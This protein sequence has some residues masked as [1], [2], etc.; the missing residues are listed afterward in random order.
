MQAQQATVLVTV[1]VVDLPLAELLALLA[2]DHK[3]RCA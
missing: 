3:L 1:D 2:L